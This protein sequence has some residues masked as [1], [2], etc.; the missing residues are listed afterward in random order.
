MKAAATLVL[1]SNAL[2]VKPSKIISFCAGI[3][4]SANACDSGNCLNSRSEGQ[5][6]RQEHRG[7]EV[8]H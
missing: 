1:V 5:E 8:V 3:E 6:K 7:S 2:D 4:I